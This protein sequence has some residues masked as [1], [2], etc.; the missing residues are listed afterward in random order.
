[1]D[2]GLYASNSGHLDPLQILLALPTND[3]RSTL[4][5]RGDAELVRLLDRSGSC[6]VSNTNRLFLSTTLTPNV[7]TAV[8]NL[9][10]TASSPLYPIYEGSCFCIYPF[11]LALAP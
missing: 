8:T 6:F 5:S 1:M 9:V 7:L 3:T 11:G 2:Y 10:S 4:S